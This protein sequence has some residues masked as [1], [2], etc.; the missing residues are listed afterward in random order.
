M[1]SGLSI[2]QRL[3]ERVP[4]FMDFADAELF[5]FLRQCDR[6][7]YAE[8]AVIFREGSPGGRMY[9]ILS[10]AVRI[11]RTTGVEKEDTLADLE[12][13]DHFGEMSLLESRPRSAR[14]TATGRSDLL[15]FTGT[16]MQSSPS[17][18]KFYTNFAR[19][20]A[21][22]LRVA[23]D[24]IVAL[25]SE[26]SVM[27]ERYRKFAARQTAEARKGRAPVDLAGAMVEGSNLRGADLRGSDLTGAR[28]QDCQMQEV[29]FRGADCRD[30]WFVD[31]DMTGVDLSGAN[32]Q[33]ATFRGTNLNEAQAAFARASGATVKHEMGESPDRRKF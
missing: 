24:R 19:V 12:S 7:Q 25:M 2:A 10:G 20:L 15:S 13:G 1:D 31:C 27:Q 29:D 18:A 3:R 28:L 8:G 4:L 22:R 32:L 23:D 16:T 21:L 14:A 26:Q 6:E 30:T 11:S 17:A 5:G 33:G 9:V